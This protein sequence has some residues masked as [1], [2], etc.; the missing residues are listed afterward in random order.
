MEIKNNMH[1]LMLK[2]TSENKESWA[3]TKVLVLDSLFPYLLKMSIPH[4][5]TGIIIKDD[6]GEIIHDV[7]FNENNE[8]ICNNTVVGRVEW[9]TNGSN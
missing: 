4:T 3:S 8:A 9:Q 2:I 6:K 5:C 1:E 7:S